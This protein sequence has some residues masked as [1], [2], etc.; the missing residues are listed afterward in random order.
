MGSEVF[1]CSIIPLVIGLLAVKVLIFLAAVSVIIF[2]Y[3]RFK[4]KK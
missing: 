3:S 4:K 1:I 2:S